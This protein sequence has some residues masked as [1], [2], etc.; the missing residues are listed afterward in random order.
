MRLNT[1]Y[2]VGALTVLAVPLSAAAQ[3]GQPYPQTGAGA[4]QAAASVEQAAP[5][6]EALM[7][8]PAPGTCPRHHRAG[9][10]PAASL[11]SW[12]YSIHHSNE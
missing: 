7:D 2:L 6:A 3:P 12:P 8:R 1:L 10:R 11:A 4:E 5:A 9:I